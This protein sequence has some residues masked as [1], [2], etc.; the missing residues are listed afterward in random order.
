[1]SEGEC[2]TNGI[3]LRPH[4][5]SSGCTHNARALRNDWLPADLFE[6]MID[7]A[8]D[9]LTP[10]RRGKSRSGQTFIIVIALLLLA[11]VGSSVFW[12]NR[13]QTGEQSSA[14]AAQT[15]AQPDASSAQAEASSS[16]MQSLNELQ[17]SI[18][19]LESSREET[20]NQ[21]DEVK[22]QL[23]TEQGERKMLAEQVG[24]LS[25]RVNGLSASSVPTA[26]V[27]TA[28]QPPQKKKPE[29]R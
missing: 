18:K 10:G 12:W 22:R 4:L 27:G 13:S 21:L 23:A 17:Q 6:A 29:S 7:P 14:A 28:K 1:V 5:S 16:M 15:S 20:V 26:T 9:T 25:G 2:Q 8:T 11:G 19:Q 24:A 3:P